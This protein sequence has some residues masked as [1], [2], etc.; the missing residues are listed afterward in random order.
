MSSIF[1]CW[2][3]FK[4]FLSSADFFSKVS[5]SKRISWEY[6]QSFK[7]FGSRSC[8]TNSQGC[9]TNLSGLIW[10]Q[11]VCKGY[12]QTTLVDVVLEPVAKYIVRIKSLWRLP[13]F[14][15]TISCVSEHR[16]TSSQIGACSPHQNQLICVYPVS[17]TVP[18]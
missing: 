16:V 7:Q 1:T 8:Q 18:L 4:Y 3:T 17:N 14:I 10:A 13:L 5:F 15:G 6:H 11:T 9:Q 2:V 12:Q